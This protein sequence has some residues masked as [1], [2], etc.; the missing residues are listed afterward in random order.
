M[1]E[2]PLYR[3][4]TAHEWQRAQE[5]GWIPR[6]EADRKDGFIHLSSAKSFLET[7]TRYF[8]PGDRPLALELDP[9]RLPG[10]IRW[11]VVPSREQRFPHFYGSSLP[12]SAVR[13]IVELHPGGDGFAVGPRQDL[14]AP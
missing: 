1:N 4:V 9:S 5:T 11:E 8:S 10:A 7:A 13:S 14:T 12:L 2:E 3:V 6:N